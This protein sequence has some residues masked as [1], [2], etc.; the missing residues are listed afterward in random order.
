MWITP[1][2]TTA[3]QYLSYKKP[4]PRSP[5]G[6]WKT[7]IPGCVELEQGITSLSRLLN[8]LSLPNTTKISNMI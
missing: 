5:R 8:F 4:Y 1:E 6:F 3:N 2:I 7:E